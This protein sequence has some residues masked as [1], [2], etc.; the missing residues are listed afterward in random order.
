M[1]K[2]LNLAKLIKTF[3]LVLWGITI[4]LLIVGLVFLFAKFNDYE[5]FT[6]IALSLAAMMSVI[7]FAFSIYA[8]IKYKEFSK[9]KADDQQ[10]TK[11]KL[12]ALNKKNKELF[13]EIQ[14]L[15]IAND[16]QLLGIEYVE[17]DSIELAN[18]LNEELSIENSRIRS[19]IES[20]KSAS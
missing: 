11:Y 1:N 12:A 17:F 19:E 7:A 15:A 14:S 10:N 9:Q 5:L 20:K 4:A 2:D 6:R 18:N 16:V 8:M 3:I 13:D